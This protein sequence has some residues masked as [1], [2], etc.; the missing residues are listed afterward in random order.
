MNK[1]SKL[2]PL[3]AQPPGQAPAAA[4]G[5]IPT[6]AGVDSKGQGQ[7]RSAGGRGVSV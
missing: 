3:S 4:P 2:S 7:A 1:L 6:D 5:H